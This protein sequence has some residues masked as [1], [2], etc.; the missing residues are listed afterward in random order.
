MKHNAMRYAEFDFLRGCQSVFMYASDLSLMQ[1]E[2]YGRETKR[3][4]KIWTGQILINVNFTVYAPVI[5]HPQEH[6]F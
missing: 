4:F 5:F 6:V 1:C 3:E 2:A